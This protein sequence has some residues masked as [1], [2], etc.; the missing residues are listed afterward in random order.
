[1][2]TIVSDDCNFISLDF[3][4]GH[5]QTLTSIISNILTS[6]GIADELEDPNCIK[7]SEIILEYV[8]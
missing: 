8:I 6:N 4:S 1:M 5:Y 7:I 2:K 3:N